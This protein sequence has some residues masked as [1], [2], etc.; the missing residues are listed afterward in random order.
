LKHRFVQ[1]QFVSIFKAR[2]ARRVDS[3]RAIVNFKRNAII[4]KLMTIKKPL[5]GIRIVSLALNIPGPV[6]VARLF[7]QGATVVKIEP[8][9]GDPLALVSPNWYSSLHE[10][11]TVVCLDLKT[12]AGQ[13]KVAELLSQSDLLITAFRPAALERLGL[14]WSTLS[15]RYPRLCQVA[16]LGYLPP[17]EA[18]PG[19]DLT[20]LAGL[21]L[22]DPPHIPRTVVA[23]LAGAE[24]AISASLALLLGRERANRVHSDDARAEYARYAAVALSDAAAALAQPLNHGLTASGGALGGGLPGY[25]VYR[26]QHGWIA[27]AALEPHFLQRLVSELGV[28]EAT[29]AAFAKAFL[30]RPAEAWEVWAA[31]RDLPIATLR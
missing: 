24:W 26:A 21:G 31:E 3:G 16:I 10:G 29:Q 14:S 28:E 20:Y 23:D 18:R 4:R 1:W 15:T 7:Q 11:I 27:V 9:G 19:H 30:A 2:P 12:N 8:P 13:A 6:A 22:L 25:N 5:Q 17:H